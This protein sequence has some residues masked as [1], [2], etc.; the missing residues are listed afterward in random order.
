MNPFSILI[1][2]VIA[3][4][5]AS[6]YNVSGNQEITNTALLAGAVSENPL[7]N[8]LIIENKAKIEG[9]KHISASIETTSE[10]IRDVSKEEAAGKNKKEEGKEATTEETTPVNFETLK[11]VETK[12]LQLTNV[13]EEEIAKISDKNKTNLEGII[14][15][16]LNPRIEGLEKSNAELNVV[17]LEIKEKLEAISKTASEPADTSTTDQKPIAKNVKK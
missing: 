3:N 4:S 14:A 10:P 2:Y 6:F 7:L 16:K 11:N 13:L 12:I 17:I 8:Y 5:R 1:N 9:D 15:E